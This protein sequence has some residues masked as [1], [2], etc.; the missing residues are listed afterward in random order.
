MYVNTIIYIDLFIYIYKSRVMGDCIS[1][2]VTWNKLKV[3]Y[4][5]KQFWNQ[6]PVHVDNSQ[7][8]A[9]ELFLLMKSQVVAMLII[10]TITTKKWEKKVGQR[11]KFCIQTKRYKNVQILGPSTISD[12][13]HVAFIGQLL[14]LV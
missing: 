7:L 8:E 2:I 9:V 13:S 6:K 11:R 10:S 1:Q 12:R 14:F 4:L 5:K 3:W